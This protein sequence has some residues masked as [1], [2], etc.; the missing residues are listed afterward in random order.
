MSVIFLVFLVSRLVNK[1][2]YKNRRKVVFVQAG[3]VTISIMYTKNENY[4]PLIVPR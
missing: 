1:T 4:V 3:R 2:K